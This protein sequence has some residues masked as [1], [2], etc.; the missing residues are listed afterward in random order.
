MLKLL[1]WLDENILQILSLVLIIFIPLYPKIPFAEIIP[2]YIVRVRIDDFLISFAILIWV[3]WL[4]RGKINLKENP[5][6]I[7]ILLYVAIG[8]L[9]SISAI[10]WTK[11]VPLQ[12]LHVSKLFLH[13]LRRIEYFSVFFIFFS[14]IKSINQ[15]KKY[16]FL[17]LVTFLAVSIYGFGQ[18]YV[19]WPAFSTMNREFSKGVYLYLSENARV[20]ST[21]GGHYD[22]AA[23]DMMLL[24]LSVPLM[25]LVRKFRLKFI[26]F[27]ISL[28]GF[29]LLI[30][31]VSRTSFIAYL[32]AIT[33]AFGFILV[34]KGFLW[35]LPRWLAVILISLAIMLFSGTLSSRFS[36]VLKIDT[37][38]IQKLVLSPFKNIKPPSGQNVAFLDVGSESDI[39]PSTKKP[40]SD[41][42][43]STKP[44]DVDG[45]IPDGLIP[46]KDGRGADLSRCHLHVFG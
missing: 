46:G 11:T 42:N 16:V 13:F 18:K 26:F 9:S 31:T 34:K 8:F 23:Y 17:I 28:F 39:P 45:D 12:E 30:L 21:F 14:S 44:A 3:I 38:Y 29:W 36:H 33:V 20:L 25:L 43:E 32:A 1:K 15:L 4:F 22:L 19:Y 37:S 40:G 10:I 2:G 41:D 27:I 35:T 24:S 5:L 7:P 6:F